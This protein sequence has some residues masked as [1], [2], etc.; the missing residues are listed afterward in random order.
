MSEV[1][2]VLFAVIVGNSFLP[3]LT[4]YIQDGND[5]VRM[6]ATAPTA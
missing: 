4:T 1:L 2:G 3:K 5:N 6:A